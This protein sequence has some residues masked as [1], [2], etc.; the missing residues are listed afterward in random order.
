MFIYWTISSLSI[1]I[2][3]HII[4]FVHWVKTTITS[5][6]A[7]A[8]LSFTNTTG[9]T[10]PRIC[11]LIRRY[12]AKNAISSSVN[13]STAPWG[14]IKCINFINTT[15]LRILFAKLTVWQISILVTAKALTYIS[16]ESQLR[17]YNTQKLLVANL[18]R[19]F[20]NLLGG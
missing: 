20:R 19:R 14:K 15:N 10:F 8:S 5:F 7:A 6:T 3:L 9:G 18:T 1:H 13:K 4:V 16:A 12:L 11:W 17:M 2:Y